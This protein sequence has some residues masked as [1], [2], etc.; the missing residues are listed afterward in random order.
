M[1]NSFQQYY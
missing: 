1:A